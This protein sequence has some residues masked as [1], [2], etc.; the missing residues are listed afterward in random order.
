MIPLPQLVPP[1]ADCTLCDLHNQ[2]PGLPQHVGISTLPLRMDVDRD[3]PVVLYVGQ[4]PGYEEDRTGIPFIGRSGRLLHNVYLNGIDATNTSNVFIT[5]A[6]RCHTLKN[7][8]PRTRH[9]RDCSPSLQTDLISLSQ[10]AVPQHILVLLGGGASTHVYRYIF[11]EKKMSLQKALARNGEVWPVELGEEI[12]GTPAWQD[13][14]VFATYH[15]AAVLR[16]PNLI[17]TVHSHNQLILDCINGVMSIP[18]VP[19]IVPC[20]PPLP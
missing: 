2:G 11:G 13:W 4:N 17:N 10:L 20:R 7:D 15:P 5:N 9:Y 16:N 3:K 6:V 14:T 18:T 8:P 12:D 1:L 19:S